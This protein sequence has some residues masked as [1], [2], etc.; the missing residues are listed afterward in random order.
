MT[1]SLLLQNPDAP[2]IAC[3]VVTD[4][5]TDGPTPGENSMRS[6]ASAVLLADGMPGRTFAA[7]LHPLPAAEPHPMT[8]AWFKQNPEA[9]QNATANPEE[10]QAVMRRYVD[11]L[12]Q[13]PWP[14]M[15]VSHPLAFDGIWMDWYLR[16]FAGQPLFPSLF[17]E[18]PP[19]FGD[20]LD[21]PT[22]IAGRLGVEYS[23]CVRQ[24]YPEKWFGGHRHTHKAL[25]DASGYASVMRHVL[26]YPA[27]PPDR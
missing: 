19:F 15:F 16:R 3:F 12:R 17:D 25:D 20:G 9:W 11:W 23:A 27:S 1:T 8:L 6:F 2:P 13:L 18:D 10:P 24:A 26:A 21:L 5:E 4:I 14:R 7:A 22:F